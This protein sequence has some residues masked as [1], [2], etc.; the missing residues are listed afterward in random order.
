MVVL[1]Y[2]QVTLDMVPFWWALPPPKWC[3]F[4]APPFLV[5]LHCKFDVSYER[6]VGGEQ[7]SNTNQGLSPPFLALG[8]NPC[9]TVASL[10]PHF[11]PHVSLSFHALF[12]LLESSSN[13][14]FTEPCLI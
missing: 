2:N 12:G 7:G 4:C 13:R 8:V 9:D 1:L 3:L 11:C 5:T 10:C 14:Y 6:W